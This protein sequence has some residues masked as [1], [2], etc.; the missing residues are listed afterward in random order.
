MKKAE[1]EDSGFV[2]TY[3]TLHAPPEGFE[4]PI[5]LA[6]VELKEGA[7][8]LCSMKGD[9]NVVIGEEVSVRREG[10]LYVCEHK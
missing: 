4:A 3:T 10:E 7:H 8:L 1:F 6:M 9:R 2:L 5:R